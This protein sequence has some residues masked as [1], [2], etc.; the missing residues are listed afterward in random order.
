M[1]FRFLAVTALFVFAFNQDAVH[2]QSPAQFEKFGDK[3]VADRNAWDEAFG[4][5]KQAYAL[6]SSSLSLRRKLADAAREVKYY[7]MAYQLYTQNYMIDEG[8]SDPNALFYMASLE[9]TMGRYED[10]QRNFKKFTKKYKA[11][12]EK[13]LVEIA[14]HEVKASQWALNK[15]DKQE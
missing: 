9:K 5:Y 13:R 7:P 4:Y 14:T 15:Q 6:D 8:K 3:A 10:A 11:T 2:A 1:R 12:A